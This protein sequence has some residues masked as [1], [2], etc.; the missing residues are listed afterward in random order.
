M[1]KGFIIIAI[2]LWTIVVVAIILLAIT[3]SNGRVGKMTTISSADALLKSEE[4]LLSSS[5]NISIETTRQNIY[6]RKTTGDKIKVSQYGN[7]DTR[8]E[9]LFIISTSSDGIYI[10]NEIFCKHN[11]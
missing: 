7:P 3:I 11:R 4:I 5:E 1:K 8:D 9:E 10:S 6:I 2:S